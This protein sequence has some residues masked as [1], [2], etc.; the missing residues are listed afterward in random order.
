MENTQAY[1]EAQMLIRKPVNEV[2][3]AFI[4]PQQTQHFWFTKSTGKLE[5]G[6]TVTW[7]WEMYNVSTEAMVKNIVPNERIAIHWGN[8]ATAVDFMFKAMPGN[9]TY[10]SIKNHG[11]REQGDDL[12]AAIRDATG[13]FTTVLDG[14]KAYLE[15]GIAL[16]L[17][18]DKFPTGK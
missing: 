4:D 7:Y 1:A 5:Q 18:A 3:N 8:P 6:A 15:H 17:I 11:F 12:I 16:N 9:H 13:G 14:L 10:V 2:F